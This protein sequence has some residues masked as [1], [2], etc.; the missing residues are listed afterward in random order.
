MIA[1]PT[2]LVTY[3]NYNVI[4]TNSVITYLLINNYYRRML[5]VIQLNYEI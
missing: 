3:K 4:I 2:N 5:E 1:L